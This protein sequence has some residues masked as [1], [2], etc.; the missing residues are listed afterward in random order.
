MRAS[1]RAI[2]DMFCFPKGFS[3]VSRMRIR[4]GFARRVVSKP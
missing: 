2:G 3:C 1:A 4:Y